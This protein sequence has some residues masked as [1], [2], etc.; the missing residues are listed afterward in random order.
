MHSII[1]VFGDI[2]WFETI[3]SANQH[4]TIILVYKYSIMHS[5]ITVFG[6]IEW[7]E[8]IKSANQ[9]PTIILV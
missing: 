9:H 8:T 6:D 7:F 5:I 1:T 2:E 4:P 3:K